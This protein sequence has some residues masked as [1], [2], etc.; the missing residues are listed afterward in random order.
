MWRMQLSNRFAMMICQAR[1]VP[2]VIKLKPKAPKSTRRTRLVIKAWGKRQP[3]MIRQAQV[4]P[5]MINRSS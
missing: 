3:V 2:T 1:V 4:T 5:L